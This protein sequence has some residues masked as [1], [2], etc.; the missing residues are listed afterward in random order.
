MHPRLWENNLNITLCATLFR[1]LIL[2]HILYLLLGLG[3]VLGLRSG[4]LRLWLV[5]VLG[6]GAFYS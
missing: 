1:C 3:S 6:Y 2:L 5:L 4:F